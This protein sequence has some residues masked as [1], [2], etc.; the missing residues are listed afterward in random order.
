MQG[1]TR[2]I[3]EDKQATAPVNLFKREDLNN[4]KKAS[5]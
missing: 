2:K 3:V 5:R 1:Y 4:S